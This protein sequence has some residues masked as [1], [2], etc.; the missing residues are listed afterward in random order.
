[1]P[2]VATFL[3]GAVITAGLA[4]QMVAPAPQSVVRTLLAARF[5][6]PSTLVGGSLEVDSAPGRGTE[7]TV[8]VPR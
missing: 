2:W 7:L 1:M 6:G 8:C 4:Y 3:Y 5:V